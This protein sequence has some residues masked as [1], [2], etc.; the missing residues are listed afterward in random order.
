MSEGHF[1]RFFH[2]AT[3]SIASTS[4]VNRIRIAR[5]CDLLSR[6]DMAVTLIA[7]EVGFNN[8][9]NFNRRFTRAQAND[10]QPVP[11]AGASALFRC[12]HAA[13]AIRG[14]PSQLIANCW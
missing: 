6:T 10:A 11:P 9:A 14:R 8:I 7:G 12:E 3:G 5:A 2:R 4:F 13:V 1:S